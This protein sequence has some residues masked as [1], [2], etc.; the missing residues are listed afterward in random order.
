MARFTTIALSLVLQCLVF[1]SVLAIPNPANTLTP[2]TLA[3]HDPWKWFW[4]SSDGTQIISIPGPYTYGF[5]NFHGSQIPQPGLAKFLFECEFGLFGQVPPSGAGVWTPY[6]A[7]TYTCN[8]NV[9][10]LP[11]SL[12]VRLADNGV[13]WTMAY[14]DLAFLI[15]MLHDTQG[16]EE[17]S[18]FFSFLF[19]YTPDVDKVPYQRVAN[20]EW[21]K[22][23]GN[24]AAATS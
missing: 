13:G 22:S 12:H 17:E 21:V 5:S 14:H 7:G 8:G 24:V 10:N 1:R 2:A 4:I 20:G 15:K 3:Q 9:P 23:V 6:P 18:P 11:T 19:N 16:V